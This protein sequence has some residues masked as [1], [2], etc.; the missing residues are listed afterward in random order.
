ME[1]AKKSDQTRKKI[2]DAAMLLF[3][4]RGAE[5][6]SVNDICKEAGV[7]VGTF[8]YYYKTKEELYLQA[9][10]VV[11][12]MVESIFPS[13]QSDVSPKTFVREFF[14]DYARQNQTMGTDGIA[15]L[16]HDRYMYNEAGGDRHPKAQTFLEEKL[17]AC[18]EQGL[19]SGRFSAAFIANELFISA[20]G[21]VLEWC[22][23]SGG[24][25]LEEAMKRHLEPYLEFYLS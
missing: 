14:A 8:Y 9:E 2:Y 21:L 22:I 24:F 12:D 1:Q 7:A 18:Q 25:D 23:H 11:Y 6:V 13:T 15:R 5:T 16:R 3:G 10:Q 20:K 19:V 4:Q 17:A